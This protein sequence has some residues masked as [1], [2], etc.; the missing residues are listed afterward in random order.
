MPITHG[1]LRRI[2]S[3]GDTPSENVRR[4]DPVHVSTTPRRSESQAGRVASPNECDPAYMYSNWALPATPARSHSPSPVTERFQ[5]PQS[6]INSTPQRTVPLSPN[7][8]HSTPPMQNRSI[9][10]RTKA[11]FGIGRGASR[12]RRSFVSMCWNVVWAVV[13]V[14]CVSRLFVLGHR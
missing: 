14:C 4:P 12:A 9:Y 2:R 3:A 5:S 1:E 6:R 7:R 8:V 13:Q 11:F 10:T